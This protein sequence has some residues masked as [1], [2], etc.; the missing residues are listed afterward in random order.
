MTWRGVV[1]LGKSLEAIKEALQTDVRFKHWLNNEAT[2]KELDEGAIIVLMIQVMVTGSFATYFKANLKMIRETI[3]DMESAGL[4]LAQHCTTQ[5]SVYSYHIYLQKEVPE[6]KYQNLLSE[7]STAVLITP[8]LSQLYK[9]AIKVITVEELPHKILQH[10]SHAQR[11]FIQKRMEDGAML[12]NGERVTIENMPLDW[13]QEMCMQHESKLK[14]ST[15]KVMALFSHESAQSTIRQLASA[16]VDEKTPD[17]EDSHSDSYT[18]SQ[19]ED[20]EEQ[21]Q[22]VEDEQLHKLIQAYMR[23]TGKNYRDKR[24][25]RDKFRNNSRKSPKSP[26][27]QRLNAIAP[28][29]AL[30][31]KPKAPS[32]PSAERPCRICGSPD[33]WMKDCPMRFNRKQRDQNFKD[34]QR[35]LARQVQYA[36]RNRDFG[37]LRRLNA[38]IASDAED[39][40][41][42]CE[43]CDAHEVTPYASETDNDDAK[44]V[45]ISEVDEEEG[46]QEA[47]TIRS[48]ASMSSHK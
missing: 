22:G 13:I 14:P 12:P 45:G 39:F 28:V 4:F 9:G 27:R 43:E 46:P 37:E 26:N 41:A 11:S 38:I 47:P 21:Q 31:S 35:R 15:A 6:G 33:H 18:S 7:F 19:S 3:V 48:G 44:S 1:T 25:N 36:R 29:S 8:I 16:I 32:Q 40:A 5:R 24:N 20:A 42:I 17:A 30:S 10:L 34:S 23:D 2:R